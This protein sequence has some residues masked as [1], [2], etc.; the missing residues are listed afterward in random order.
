MP[1]SWQHIRDVETLG[2]KKGKTYCELLL[3]GLVQNNLLS[4]WGVGY[5]GGVCV[6]SLT[7]NLRE[8]KSL[9]LFPPESTTGLRTGRRWAARFNQPA[10]RLASNPDL[11]IC[12]CLFRAT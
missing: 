7:A 11:Q 5:A 10:M 3:G 12:K 9:Y 8:H 6:R 4:G 2:L 1:F